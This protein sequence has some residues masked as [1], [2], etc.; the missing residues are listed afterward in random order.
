MTASP[1][2]HL[3]LKRAGRAV[4]ACRATGL[5]LKREIIMRE[6][7]F[8]KMQGCGNDF[9]VIDNRQGLVNEEGIS[10]L[11]RRVCARRVSLGADGLLLVEEGPKEMPEMRLFNSDG[12]EGEMCGNGA[13]CF[14]RFISASH[15]DELSFLTG[16]GPV[17]AEVAGSFVRI[18]LE[19]ISLHNLLR[20]KTTVGELILPFYFLTVG[21]PHCVIFSDEASLPKEESELRALARELRHRLDLFPRGS[22]INF[23]TSAREEPLHILTY[24]RGVEDFTLACGTG[25][26]A[27]AIAAVLSGRGRAP[28]NIISRG[29]LLENNFSISGEVVKE[30]RQGGETRLVAEGRLLPEAWS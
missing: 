2:K 16:T 3:A 15:K 4:L 17:K 11:A 5:R 25:A 19:D 29:G 1:S 30:V 28:I 8:K 6:L 27:T 22:N 7:F 14:A 12:S 18:S 20:D 21:V 26:M 9:I 13:R 10:D 24:E 23:V